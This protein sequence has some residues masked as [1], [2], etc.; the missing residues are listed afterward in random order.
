MKRVRTLVPTKYLKCQ[1]DSKTE[2]KHQQRGCSPEKRLFL[3]NEQK[4]EL[5]VI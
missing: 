1:A 5:N 2:G 4:W 3:N